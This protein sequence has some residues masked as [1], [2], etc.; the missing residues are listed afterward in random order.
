MGENEIGRGQTSAEWEKGEV[1][2]GET[3]MGKREKF[4]RNGIWRTGNKPLKRDL[5][6]QNQTTQAEFLYICSAV[7]I[8]CKLSSISVRYMSRDIIHAFLIPRHT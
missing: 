8:L 5:Q 6:Y 3:R 2:K 7:L 4:G 1:G